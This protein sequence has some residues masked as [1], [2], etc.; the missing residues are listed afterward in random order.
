MNEDGKC[1]LW[2]TFVS[3]LSPAICINLCAVCLLKGRSPSA[4]APIRHAARL[5]EGQSN[6]ASAGV[7]TVGYRLVIAAFQKET[8]TQFTLV[9]YR[10]VPP[11]LQDLVA[12]QIDF[13]FDSPLSLA[14]L[15]AG[16]VKAL[17]VT[18]DTRIAL[19]PDI[20]TFTE[21]GLP[22]VSFLTWN[23]LF[24]PKGTPREIIN[25]LNAA[26]VEALADPAVRSRF[27]ALGWEI[28]PREQQTP[29]ALG[30]LVKAD[31]E[32]WWP[33]IKELGIKPE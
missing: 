16:S 14:Q 9:P 22:T 26:M 24:A 20:P 30:A 29:E 27:A 19:A 18:S 4:M 12:G 21:M 8:G 31:A 7:V 1:F 3:R 23:G 5:V 33:I 13:C 6:K 11:E 32:K 10:G 15:R 25:K 28:F 17:A 2:E